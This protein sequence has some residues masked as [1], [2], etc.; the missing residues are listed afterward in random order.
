MATKTRIAC[1][2]GEIGPSVVLGATTTLLG[3]LP[4]AFAKTVI[5]RIFFKMFVLIIGFGVSEVRRA[6]EREVL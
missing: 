1:A 4:L 5:F 6:R 2:L 3:I